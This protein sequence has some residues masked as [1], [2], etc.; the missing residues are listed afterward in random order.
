[1]FSSL[2]DDRRPDQVSDERHGGH[3]DEGEGGD[4]R[5]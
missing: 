1:M 2:P 4:G 3:G 5:L